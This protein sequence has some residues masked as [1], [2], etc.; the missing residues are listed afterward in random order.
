ML[1]QYKPLEVYCQPENAGRSVSLAD[2]ANLTLGSRRNLCLQGDDCLGKTGTTFPKSREPVTWPAELQ[3]L[4]LNG[5]QYPVFP[6]VGYRCTD[7]LSAEA[8]A[9]Q[10]VNNGAGF[11]GQLTSLPIGEGALPYH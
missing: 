9:V 5:T 7:G 10:Q 3:V 1:A 8:L 4:K 6:P 2:G 11:P